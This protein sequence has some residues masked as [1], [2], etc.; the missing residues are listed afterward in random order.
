MFYSQ[1]ILA[2]KGPLG[3]VWLAAH[4]GDKKLGRPQIFST[5]ISSSVDSIVNPSVPL[6]LRVSGHLLLGVVRIYSRKVK[7]L[8]HDCHEAMVKIKMAF[9]TANGQ[10]KEVIVDLDPSKTDNLNVA[11]FGEITEAYLLDD[12]QP[13]AIP[14]DL[15]ALQTQNPEEWAVA[16]DNED[17]QNV[18]PEGRRAM[19]LTMDSDL[20]RT[21]EPEEQWTAFDP[22]E[23]QDEDRHVF[24]DSRNDESKISDVELVRGAEDSMTTAEGQRLSILDQD[25]A[26]KDKIVSS[27]MSEQEFPMPDDDNDISN[28]AFDDDEPPTGRDS[29]IKLDL[30]DSLN[31]NTLIEDSIGGLAV[32]PDQQEKSKKR[33]RKTGPKRMRKRRKVVI[34]NDNTQLSGEHIKAMLDDP[35]DICLQTRIHPADWAQG[36]ESRTTKLDL[37]KRLP[38]DR[39]IVRPQL[40]DDAALSPALLQVWLN[41]TA[42]ARGKPK[43]FRLRGK[44]GEEQQAQRRIE[45]DALAE[46][47]E[48]GRQGRD[49]EHGEGQQS[50]GDIEV[51]QEQDDFPPPD[52]GDED[53]QIPFDD[54]FEGTGH[55]DEE[56]TVNERAKSSGSAFELGLVNDFEEDIETDPRQAAGG[57][58]ISSDSKWHKHTVKV[59]SM[60]KKQMG[61]GD[62]DKEGA[63]NVSELSY[64][65][66]S[67]GCS[68]HTAA[69]VFF[70]LLQLKTWDFIEL[71]QEESYGD[72]KVS[73]ICVI[74]LLPR[75]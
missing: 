52:L 70:E 54:E 60:L 33:Q 35:S 39:L 17:S 12:P 48:I 11:N 29:G 3:K 59:L 72:I 5:D 55:E 34:D 23:E 2:K 46:E 32:S 44:A 73:Y 30:E 21:E 6:A 71:D 61:N 75:D 69:S 27:R 53:M 19:D 15:H 47:I 45:Q 63:A 67:E 56:I 66:L 58:L 31:A 13:F 36:E 16:E 7:Y 68:R 4:W 10:I 42:E 62:D 8:M 1:I 64:D 65:K 57:D 38:F 51:Q 49:S 22:D 9:S 37:R 24:D 41:N 74:L 18:A 14:F 50:V 20:G 43:A 26:P 28:I 40:A 25:D